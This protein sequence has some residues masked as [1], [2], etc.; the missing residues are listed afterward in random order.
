[1]FSDWDKTSFLLNMR[2]KNPVRFTDILVNGVALDA[3]KIKN[4]LAKADGPF[5]QEA[6]N[7]SLQ[8]LQTLE[9]S[10]RMTDDGIVELHFKAPYESQRLFDQV[11]SIVASL[12]LRPSNYHVHDIQ[13]F[14]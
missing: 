11:Q 3:Q 8:S 6:A 13:R 10:V 5:C 12:K 1:M 9:N 2:R 7:G 14:P 4:T